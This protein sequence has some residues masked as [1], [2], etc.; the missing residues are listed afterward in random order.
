MMMFLKT[1]AWILRHP[2]YA[3]SWYLRGAV[4]SAAI[5]DEENNK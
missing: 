3:A 5:E 1:M 2:L 4:W